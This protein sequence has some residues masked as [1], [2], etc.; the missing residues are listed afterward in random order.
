M[1]LHLG[2][3]ETV[4]FVFPRVSLFPS[5]QTKLTVI[6]Q[7]NQFSARKHTQP[8]PWCGQYLT[9]AHS[10][11]TRAVAAMD[12]CFVLILTY[13]RSQIPP[14]TA[15]ASAL[16]QAPYSTLRYWPYYGVGCVCFLAE[17]WFLFPR[18]PDTTYYALS[19]SFTATRTYSV[20]TSCFRLLICYMSTS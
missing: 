4:S 10:H 15:E 2:N 6:S 20:L 19:C 5:T 8:T 14:F 12:S 3:R 18:G 9:H 13:L 17:N 1:S 11:V 7:R 16:L